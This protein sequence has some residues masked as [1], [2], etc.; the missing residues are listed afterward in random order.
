MAEDG[1]ITP[2]AGFRRGRVDDE[3]VNPDLYASERRFMP[4][5]K[6]RR[7]DPLHWTEPE[8]FRPFWSVTKHADILEIERQHERFVNA[9]A[10]I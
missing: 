2:F 3:I 10:P 9:R 6:L 8:G 4:S 1:A 7:E 5:S